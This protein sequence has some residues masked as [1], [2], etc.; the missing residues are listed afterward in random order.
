MMEMLFDSAFSPAVAQFL[1]GIGFLTVI[2]ILPIFLFFRYKLAKHR[3]NY[4]DSLEL[5]NK[6]LLEQKRLK[7]LQKQADNLEKRLF[8]LES[9]LDNKAPDWKK[10]Q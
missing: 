4:Q 7:I 2:L 3:I 5:E 6:I 8:V 1:M 9:I 10:L